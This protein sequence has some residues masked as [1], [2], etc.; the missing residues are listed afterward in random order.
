MFDSRRSV[1][2]GS[3][4]ILFREFRISLPDISPTVTF[5]Q[6]SH[7]YGDRDASAPYD[8]LPSTDARNNFNSVHMHRLPLEAGRHPFY[9][10][11]RFRRF[12]STNCTACAG[13]MDSPRLRR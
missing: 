6:F 13:V 2:Q 10:Y 11:T 8:R 1:L 7:N 5:G 12:V 9:F 4:D 3:A